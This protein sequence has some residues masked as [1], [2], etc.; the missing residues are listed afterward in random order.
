MFTEQ[1][2]TPNQ[3]PKEDLGEEGVKEGGSKEEEEED[4]I[5][6]TP[7]PREWECL[8]SDTEIRESLVTD[9]RPLVREYGH[10]F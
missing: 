3:P 7:V 10:V 6:S 5:P 4:V 2:L 8:G 1:F 9:S